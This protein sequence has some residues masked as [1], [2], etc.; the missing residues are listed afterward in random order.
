MPYNQSEYNITMNDF[1]KKKNW[2]CVRFQTFVRCV[3]FSS[4]IISNAE[5]AFNLFAQKT[6][7]MPIMFVFGR[8]YISKFP[9][10]MVVAHVCS[11]FLWI[12]VSFFALFSNSVF[13]ANSLKLKRKKNEEQSNWALKRWT[14]G[15]CVRVYATQFTVHAE[16]RMSSRI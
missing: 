14:N 1:S 11:L 8:E 2:I 6:R 7:L 9:V 16:C 15:I 5:S 4:D 10:Y 12:L 13:V 3:S